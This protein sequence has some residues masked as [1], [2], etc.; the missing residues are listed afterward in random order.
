MRKGAPRSISVVAALAAVVVGLMAPGAIG[1][2]E[3][4]VVVFAIPTPSASPTRIA[5]GPD[6]AMWFTE[7]DYRANKIGRV[8]FGG[9][10]TEFSIPTPSSSPI[11][12]TAGPDGALCFTEGDKLGRI[13]TAG[14][15]TEFAVPTP[16]ESRITTA[17]PVTKSGIS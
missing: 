12:I 4:N 8:T 15:I 3:A 11:G 1:V 13:T 17:G 14:A 16:S 10:I 6:G 5:L 9:E 7:Y 2:P